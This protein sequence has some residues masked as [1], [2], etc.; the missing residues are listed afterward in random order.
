MNKLFLAA[1]VSGALA[2]PAYSADY[3]I[4]A[5]AAPGGGWDSTARTMQEAMQTDGVSPSVQVVNVAGAGGTIGL[6]QFV[7]Q[8]NGD[9]SQLM[10]AGYVMV[11]AI[12][13]NQSP[14]SLADVTPIARL[15]SEA[16]VLVVP[17]DSPIKTLADLVAKLKAD[18][19]S[20]SWAGGS[21]GG[22][23]HIAAGLIA[24]AVGADPTQVNYIAYSGGGEAL[25]SV[26]GSQV[27]VGISGA[28]EFL[29]QVDAGALRA[30][31]VTGENRV[32][33]Y[34]IPTLK[35]AGV[36]V[37]ME[38]WRMVAAAPGI[39]PEQETAISDDIKKMV[40]GP[41]WQAALKTRGWANAYLA[42]DAFDTQLA[43]DVEATTGILKEIG[44]VQ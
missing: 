5:P 43:D 4:M 21:A 24:K 13:A 37:V 39:T 22:A 1:L 42:G 16:D 30:I 31:A 10:V 26:L 34:D 27:T 38:N 19:G 11:G 29:P 8:A 12:L 18:T 6:A 2:L 40:D 17:A 35:E 36:D 3:T 20:V 7:S 9:P 14:M 44:L 15:T 25:A 28:S 32:E 23:D 41:T 33:G